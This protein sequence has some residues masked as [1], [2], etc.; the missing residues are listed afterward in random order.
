M[1][2]SIILA[3]QNAIKGYNHLSVW[4]IQFIGLEKKLKKKSTD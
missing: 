1:W 4:I 2:D 3:V